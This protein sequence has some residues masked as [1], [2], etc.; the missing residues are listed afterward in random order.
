MKQMMESEAPPEVER[1]QVVKSAAW[2]A[3]VIAAAVAAPMAAAS[4]AF[5]DVGITGRC[6]T[7][8]LGILG[9]SRLDFT[10]TAVQGTVPAGTSF[11]LTSSSLLDVSALAA[12]PNGLVSIS[13]L[14]G[15]SVILT[16]TAP[17]AQGSTVTIDLLGQFVTVGLVYTYTLQLNGTDHPSSPTTAAPNSASVSALAQLNLGVKSLVCL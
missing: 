8:L 2:A 10:I 16:L 12:S 11:T 5:W 7:G 6:S 3:P 13:L 15:S 4:Q 14:S 9:Q 17:L 1:R